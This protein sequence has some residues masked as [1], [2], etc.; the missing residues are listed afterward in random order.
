VLFLKIITNLKSRQNNISNGPEVLHTAGIST[1]V[2]YKEEERSELV[3]AYIET[4]TILPKAGVFSPNQQVPSLMN[5]PF[6]NIKEFILVP[7]EGSKI[8]E[9]VEIAQ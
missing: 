6:S 2:L 4:Q 9:R 8:R 7:K 1:L 3:A 5:I